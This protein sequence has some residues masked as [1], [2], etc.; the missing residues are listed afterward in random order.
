[1]RIGRV[2]RYESIP[3]ENLG[4]DIVNSSTIGITRA[5]EAADTTVQDRPGIAM[6]AANRFK[7]LRDVLVGTNAGDYGARAAVSG[8]RLSWHWMK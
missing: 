8:G 5:Y 2:S 4:G 7:G 3:Y 1:M 6:L